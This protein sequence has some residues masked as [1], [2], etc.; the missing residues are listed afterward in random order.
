MVCELYPQAAISPEDEKSDEVMTTVLSQQRAVELV[1]ELLEAK[2]CSP[3]E[4][5]A[6]ANV[7]EVRSLPAHAPLVHARTRHPG[8]LVVLSGRLSLTGEQ[9]VQ[10]LLR[11]GDAHGDTEVILD[12]PSSVT[13][14]AL[15]DSV[16]AIIPPQAFRQLLDE[17]PQW[18]RVW[19]RASAHRV[20]RTQERLEH[21]LTP[22]LSRRLAALLL[23]RSEKGQTV[24]PQEMLAQMLAVQR[25]SVNRILKSLEESK[26]VQVGY[27]SVRVLDRPRLSALRH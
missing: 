22:G 19:L 23:D 17:Y 4:V 15:E 24:L 12:A 27:G 14:R 9:G 5:Q 21:L 11:V 20:A 10:D 25:P 7:L 18:S 16:V 2:E 6:L 3:R 13:I 1:V 26:L 8:P